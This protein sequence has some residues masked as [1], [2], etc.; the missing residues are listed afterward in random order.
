MKNVKLVVIA[1]DPAKHQRRT[2]GLAFNQSITGQT[3]V[4]DGGNLLT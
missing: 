3:I 1:P 4:V 2:N